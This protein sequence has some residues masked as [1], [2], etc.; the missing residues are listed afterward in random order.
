M[1]PFSMISAGLGVF[2]FLGGLFGAN[3]ARNAAKKQQAH[4]EEQARLNRA[5][6]EFNVKAIRQTGQEMSIGAAKATRSMISAQRAIFS[7]RGITTE[8]SPMMVMGETASMGL[9][10]IQNIYFSSQVQ[11]VDARYRAQAAVA[12]A[13]NA[14]EGANYQAKQSTMQMVKMALGG[15][16]IINDHLKKGT[17]PKFSEFSGF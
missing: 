9:Q 1:E 17:M 15:A 5:M 12:Q 2:N 14:A 7:G 4:Y 8:G 16:N 6:G 13:E 10:K 11:E 3:N